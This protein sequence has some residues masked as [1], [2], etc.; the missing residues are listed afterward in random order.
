MP[1]SI[2]VDLGVGPGNEAYNYRVTTTSN[3]TIPLLKVLI[4]CFASTIPPGSFSILTH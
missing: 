3:C 2:G 1:R 4:G